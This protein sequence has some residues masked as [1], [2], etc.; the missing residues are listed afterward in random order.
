MHAACGGG[1]GTPQVSADEYIEDWKMQFHST[2]ETQTE[3]LRL[4]AL[5]KGVEAQS[6]NQVI[7]KLI[8]VRGRAVS[9]D[10]H[11]V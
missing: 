10:A 1:A 2:E 7:F 11:L 8:Q 5:A 3:I 4:S 6:H 9:C